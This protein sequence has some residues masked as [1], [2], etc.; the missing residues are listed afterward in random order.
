MLDPDPIY[1]PDRRL[2]GGANWGYEGPIPDLSETKIDAFGRFQ[3]NSAPGHHQSESLR[4]KGNP[5]SVGN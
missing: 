4:E 2:G 3:S 5:S 1:K